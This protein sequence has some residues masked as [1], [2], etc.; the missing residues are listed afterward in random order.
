MKLDTMRA[1]LALNLDVATVRAIAERAQ[2]L[3]GDPRSPIDPRASTWVPATKMHVT[4]KFFGAID[5]G[6]APAIA[7]AVRPI[8]EAAPAV[9]VGEGRLAAFPS[10]DRARVLVYELSDP[11]GD[12]AELFEAVESRV[13]ALGVPREARPL[14]PH[15]TLA[16]TR[17][18][19]DVAALCAAA[20]VLPLDA[21]TVP[22]LVLYRS[23]VARAG[24]EYDRVAR[25]DLPRP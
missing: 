16:R 7:D 1:F 14:R 24:A 11:D 10:N 22:E 17:A 12:V 25:F 5:V 21:A 2:A 3:K 9:R 15:V 18:K 23:D 6:L 19:V 13:E 8:A 4:L 20:P